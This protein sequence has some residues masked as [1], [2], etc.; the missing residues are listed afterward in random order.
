MYIIVYIGSRPSNPPFL[1]PLL[2]PSDTSSPP[3]SDLSL[4]ESLLSIEIF[5]PGGCVPTFPRLNY[6]ILVRKMP[7]IDSFLL[8]KL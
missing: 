4:K 7:R 8:Y 1:F 3:P 6:F 2:M 5:S